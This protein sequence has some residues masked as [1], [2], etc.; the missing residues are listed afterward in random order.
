[1]VARVW[2][3]NARDGRGWR[4]RRNWFGHGAFWI[5]LSAALSVGC[6]SSEQSNRGGSS[7][8]SGMSSDGQAGLETACD[9][10]ACVNGRVQLTSCTGSD[11]VHC[12]I[13]KSGVECV[14]SGACPDHP[15]S[16]FCQDW[17]DAFAGFMARCGCN[18]KAVARYR[19]LNTPALCEPQGAFGGLVEATQAGDF[20]YH[21]EAA[22]KLFERLKS[23]DAPCVDEPFRALRLD[24]EALYSLGGV[25]EG[26]RSL[27]QPCRH[28]VGYKG[29]ISDCSEGICAPDDNGTGVCVALVGKGSACDDGGDK[30][31][32]ASASR[33][34]HDLR[35]ADDDGEY[36]AAFDSLACIQPASG[37]TT[38]ICADQLADGAVCSS[39][40]QCRSG[41]CLASGGNGVCAAKFAEGEPCKNHAECASGACSNQEPRA[42]RS[43]LAENEA[44]NYSDAAC[45][46][47]FCNDLLA[48]TESFCAPAPTRQVGESCSSASECISNGHGDSR[49]RSCQ[50]GHCVNDICA[51]YAE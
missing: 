26:T 3:S 50:E 31:F 30:T 36:Q 15:P 43:L 40:L 39:P 47:G 41:N 34:C 1:M 35:L 48:G 9:G 5:A 49:R 37:S 33:I 32:D 14:S 45:A 51:A 11:F 8:S 18:A 21:A 23:S 4:G 12:D 27:G 44:C 13:E 42:C 46:T 24:S 10:V 38:R 22:A 7:G 25:F 28:P 29:G 19:E 2:T 20:V 16:Q 17:L 6:G